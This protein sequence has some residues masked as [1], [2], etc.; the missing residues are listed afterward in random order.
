[1]TKRDKFS[2]N[3]R[4][5]ATSAPFHDQ[6]Y[7]SHTYLH[8]SHL[9]KNKRSRKDYRF[10]VRI[11]Y[12][13]PLF[14][15]VCGRYWNWGQKRE[16]L[17]P[18]HLADRKSR[19]KEFAEAFRRRIDRITTA[20]I[21]LWL[22]GFQG[23]RRTQRNYRDAILQLFRFARSQG[24]LPKNEPTAVDEIEIDNSAEGEIHI[25]ASAEM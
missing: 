3:S 4:L 17:S 7:T 8:L 13:L 24:C 14:I 19:L 22:R 15:R 1:M 20:E 2:V 6:A 23:A 10:R 18:L 12:A 25:Y 16:G 9:H 21:K 5:S 11:P